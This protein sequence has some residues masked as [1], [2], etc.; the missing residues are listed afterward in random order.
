MRCNVGASLAIAALTSL[1]CYTMAPLSWEDITNQRPARVWVTQADRSRIVVNGPQV[2][3]DTLVGYIAGT[4]QELPTADIAQV[5]IKRAA[6]GRTMAL[7]A[8]SIAGAAALGVFIS[9]IGDRGN[10]TD[11]NEFPDEPECQGQMP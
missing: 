4:F 1:G 7:I 11:C 8:A 9:G 6:K 3:G 5:V 10:E 2:F